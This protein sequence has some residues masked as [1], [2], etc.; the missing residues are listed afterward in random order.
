MPTDT[1]DEVHALLDTY[2]SRLKYQV[3][4]KV[5]RSSA[6]KRLGVEFVRKAWPII[7]KAVPTERAY[8]FRHRGACR[9]AGVEK[10]ALK[11]HG[12][13][14]TCIDW[15]GLGN[16][17]GWLGE[18]AVVF[19]VWLAD[20]I[21]HDK[22]H[23]II[24]E[25]VEAFDD[26]MLGELCAPQGFEV[27]TLSLSPE[28]FAFPAT[29][30]RKYMVMLNSSILAWDPTVA[31]DPAACFARLFDRPCILKGDIFYNAP[32]QFIKM[33]HR[34]WARS[35]HMPEVQQDG[36]EWPSK[37][38]LPKLARERVRLWEEPLG[39]LCSSGFCAC[40]FRFGHF[41]VQ[42]VKAR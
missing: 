37:L 42:V 26:A 32:Q 1:L 16:T 31:R 22:R 36:N 27:L 18:S 5:A 25:C 10:E 15:S 8:C 20:Q 7:S 2:R 13:G 30:R 21:I 33:F 24:A 11:G 17:L 28:Q 41:L 4:S 34:K 3:Q 14:V 6:V 40:G 9:C 35:K 19:M 38:L 39:K 29:R 23:F 12:A